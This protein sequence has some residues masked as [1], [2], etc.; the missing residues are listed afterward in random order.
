MKPLNLKSIDI[1]GLNLIE[2]S[3][4]TG[5]TWTIAALYILLLLEKELRPE[6]ILVVTYTKAATSELRDRIRHRISTTL[7]I[8]NG[9]RAASDDELEQLLMKARPQNME[10]ASQLLTRALYSFDEAAIFTIHG[11]CQR[12]LMENA[13]ESGS[14]FDSEMITDQSAIVG[15]VCDDFWRTNILGRT[16]DMVEYLVAEDFTP[17][18]LAKPFENH[19]QNPNLK[20]IPTV[21]K[22]DTG[23]LIS[24]YHTLFKQL[25][26]LWNSERYIILTQLEK[27]N[28]NQRSYKK[29]QIDAA[30]SRLD[31]WVSGGDPAVICNTLNLFSAS[32]ISSK[33]TRATTTIPDHPVFLLCQKILEVESLL[34]QARK[35]L[36]ISCRQELK[37]WLARELPLRK[38]ALN[39][40]CFD[41]LLLDLNLALEADSGVDLAARLRDRYRAALIDEFQD[42]DPLQW[43]I[44]KKLSNPLTSSEIESNYPLF[45]IGDPKQAIYSFRGA[46]V[47]AYLNAGNIVKAE[48]R[49]TLGTNF[50]SVPLLVSAINNLFSSHPDPFLCKDISFYPVDS[51]RPD[52]DSLL[53]DGSTDLKP[54][55]VWIYP[56]ADQTKT[57]LK[58]VATNKT[59]QAVAYEIARLLEKGRY[60][61]SSSGTPRQLSPN[62]IAVL[63]KSHKQ[64]LLVQQA[65][66]EIH[67][68][69]VQH[70]S[71]TVL[72]SAEALDLLRIMRAA[73]EPGRANLL[74]EALLTSSMGLS[75]NE[76]DDFL[77]SSGDHPDWEEWLLRF[78][79]LGSAVQSGGIVALA[80][81]LLGN[82]GLKKRLLS[83]STGE[84]ALTN[85]L[86]CFELLHQAELESGK[87]LSGSINRLERLIA[88]NQKNDAYLL[89]LETDDTAVNISTIHA[90]K[91]LQY[92]VVFVPF[93]WDYSSGKAGRIIFHDETG[94]LVLD[95]AGD[96]ANRQIALAEMGAEA[97]RLLYV[98]LT[99]AEFRCYTV[100]GCINSAI[101]S[102][103][104]NLFHSGKIAKENKAFAALTDQAVLDDVMKL[105]VINANGTTVKM[106]PPNCDTAD[107][108]CNDKTRPAPYICRRLAIPPKDNWRVSSFSSI[109]SGTGHTFQPR[110]HDN[111]PA[112]AATGTDLQT[113]ALTGGLTI[114]D[115]PR[116]ARAGT[117]LHEIFEQ[118]DFTAMTKDNISSI[119]RN[120]L[121]ANG[122]SDRWLPAVSRMVTDVASASILHDDSGFC[123]SQLKKGTWQTEMEFY[124][125]LSQL[126]PDTLRSIFRGLMDD[127]LFMD[128]EDVLNGLSFKINRGML[129]GFID[130]LFTHAGRYYL[131]DWKSNYLGSSHADYREEQMHESMCRSA[132]ILQYHLYALALDRMLKNRL[133]DYDYET[134]F[135]GAIYLY[136]RGVTTED[137]DS[138]IYHARPSLEFIERSNE[139]MLTHS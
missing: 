76:I 52:G 46:D 5:K 21:D 97:A 1:S 29:E 78:R 57:E 68:P 16:D 106:M 103:L 41:D 26:P 11:F 59:V 79:E 71:S 93:A 65:L 13:F 12:V 113:E 132:Y 51:G 44:F 56:R 9:E 125:P 31:A 55:H 66:R 14:L 8:Y 129:Q 67:I 107:Y 88:D 70:G 98:A 81:R 91:G 33:T 23:P 117:C 17:E 121:A 39:L 25:G 92:P 47:F 7:E 27:A 10:R 100:W 35:G 75:A 72:K 19:Y 83:R 94:K 119:T 137:T 112:E 30:G 136:L 90:S 40:R 122:F 60:Q 135:G 109:I 104:F 89:R 36:V 45:L 95:L 50:R 73:A 54:L 37:N 102:P 111:I 115:F 87:N 116:G 24:L 32:N 18:K 49:Q 105:A 69:S 133:K 64:A 20:V 128:F 61:I 42:T 127:R 63:V 53:V 34:E 134:H 58:P 101:D 4:G 126:D 120:S 99:R 3:A 124:L 48:K 131:L 139:I 123:L 86:H 6:Q 85:I 118:L 114:F 84:R 138:G 80:E 62:D 28:L 43:N 38:K 130:L 108:N 2:A 110:D 77:Q 96:D 15:Q 22:I 74:R 82:C